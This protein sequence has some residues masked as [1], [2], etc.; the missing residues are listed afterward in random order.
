VARRV[1]P[2][3]GPWRADLHSHTYASKDS[4]T[5]PKD[6]IERAREIGLAKLAVTDHNTIEGAREAYALAPDLIIIGQEIDTAVG[7]ELIAYFVQ[8]QIP[9]HLPPEEAIARLRAQGAVI[10]LSHPLDRLRNS[11]MGEKNTLALIDKV[12]A[13]E[14]FNAR[15]LLSADNRRAAELAAR[16]GKLGTAGSDGHTL[17]EIGAAYVLL[18]PF[19]GNAEAFRASLAKGKAEGRI[20]GIIPHFRSTLAK[21]TKKKQGL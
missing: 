18:P 17:P 11:A 9:K 10:S 8:E 12:D 3:V 2:V 14:V 4:L 20:T 13:L 6:L 19:K 7:G 15:C 21:R 5:N 1:D 16:Y